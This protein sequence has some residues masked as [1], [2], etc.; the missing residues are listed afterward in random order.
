ML[1]IISSGV[2]GSHGIK[3]IVRLINKGEKQSLIDNIIDENL[4]DLISRATLCD[5]EQRASFEE[6]L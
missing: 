3:K 4:R 1:E 2:P 6:L 5:P